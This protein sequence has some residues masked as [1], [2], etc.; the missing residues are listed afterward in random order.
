MQ[1][2]KGGIKIPSPHLIDSL[3]REFLEKNCIVLPNFLD[4]NLLDQAIINLKKEDFYERF[5]LYD[6]NAAPT[7]KNTMASELCLK[8]EHRL[9]K[10][11]NLILNRQELFHYIE[12]ITG[13]QKIKGFHARV[14]LRSSSNKHYDSWH[15][16]L[17][18]NNE[19]LIAISINLSKIPYCGGS[20]KIRDIESK[21]LFKEVEYAGYSTAHLFKVA[22][23]LEHKVERVVGDNPRIAC[24]GWFIKSPFFKVQ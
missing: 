1:V 7:E 21:K 3:K 23:N 10:L 12:M 2:S 20:F 17:L 16:D 13:C 14:F 22:S 4:A 5:H 8:P 15:T 24:A 9:I 6:Y 19:R 11:L 18:H